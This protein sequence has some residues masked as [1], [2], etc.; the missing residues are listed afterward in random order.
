MG[1][2]HT[3]HQEGQARE[4]SQP[5]PGFAH[6]AKVDCVASWH[7]DSAQISSHV[8]GSR[9]KEDRRERETFYSTASKLK[10]KIQQNDM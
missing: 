2:A 5:E 10:K 3:S 8:D 6:S 1:R 4:R 7:R 9:D